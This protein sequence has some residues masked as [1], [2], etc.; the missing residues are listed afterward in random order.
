MG[1][2]IGVD[3]AGYGPV[4]GPLVV[5]S[6]AFEAPDAATED[7]LW[8]AL[9]PDLGVAERA[10]AHRPWIADSKLIHQGNNAL[11][12][13]ERN[14]LATCPLPLPVRFEEFLR[15]LGVPG[16][17]IAE[18]EPWHA[19]DFP[20]LPLEADVAEIEPLRQGF[21]R[22]TAEAD[23][24]FLGVTA[25][26]AQP[27]RFNRLVAQTDNKATVLWL[28]AVEV[29]EKALSLER[30][31]APAGGLPALEPARITMDKHGGRAYYAKLLRD[32]WPLASV[33]VL[34][35]TPEVSRYR[36]QAGR[37]NAEFTISEK[38]ERLSLPV[39]LASM[40]AKYVREVFMAQFNRWWVA[41]ARE[42]LP[43]L[44][45]AAAITAGYWND[46][47]RWSRAVAP[48]LARLLLPPEEFI[49][50]R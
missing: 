4:L 43:A 41:R 25:N 37:L 26:V 16:E 6:T 7:G 3:E 33:D 13:L 18:R 23:V 8:R 35:E 20:M 14:V 50:R 38:A 24:Q 30:Q 9:Q 49:R 27:W 32:S 1:L 31:E 10:S 21:R 48:L 46:Y 44:D 36:V 19:D 2:V 29:V 40:Y 42:A 34:L 17:H 45:P 28:L 12:R 5:A 15:W 22:A 39:A 11:Q 47:E